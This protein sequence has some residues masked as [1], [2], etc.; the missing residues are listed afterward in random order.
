MNLENLLKENNRLRHQVDV[1]TQK[2]WASNCHEKTTAYFFLVNTRYKPTDHAD[3][4]RCI[5][6]CD[7]IMRVFALEIANLIIFNKK[8][9]NFSSHYIKSVSIR[10]CVEIGK[11]ILKKNGERGKTGGTVHIHVYV[12]IKHYSNIKLEYEQ[13][14]DFF[15][16]Q[17]LE[18]F[19]IDKIFLGRL[20]L[21]NVN[22]IEEYM[23]KDL[24]NAEWSNIEY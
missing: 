3:A 15:T 9:H 12:I 2:N 6:L 14:R 20:R 7:E 8:N 4:Q 1:L 21:V 22:R 16:A 19:G 17:I 5:E 11:G 23:T 24:Q 13:L 10:Y 18:K